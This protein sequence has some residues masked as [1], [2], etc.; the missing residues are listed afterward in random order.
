MSRT[1]AGF[2]TLLTRLGKSRD[3]I[4]VTSCV[5]AFRVSTNFNMS[6]CASYLV[7]IVEAIGVTGVVA[8]AVGVE[9]AAVLFGTEFVPGGTLCDRFCALSEGVCE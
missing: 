3:A 9:V 6:L 8:V 2:R 4:R 5:I 1:A 7:P